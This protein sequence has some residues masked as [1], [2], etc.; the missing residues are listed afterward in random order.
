MSPL[1][2]RGA[3]AIRVAA[4]ALT[5]TAGFAS[6]APLDGLRFTDPISGADV[7]LE[8]GPR[9][10]HLVFLATWCPPCVDELE[11]LADLVA[12]WD[13]TGY[14]LVL[15]AVPSR[16]SSERLQR[17][18]RE[19]ELPGRLLFDADGRAQRAFGVVDV[20]T[21]VVLDADG[22]EILRAESAREVIAGI[23]PLFRGTVEPRTGPRGD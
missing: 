20:P 13:D 18:L 22:A 11:S 6:A 15:I 23:E 14:E 3:R 4:C 2:I 9:A 12:R 19:R 5:L 8:P 10:L 16:Q 21:H 1:G 7:G 17:W